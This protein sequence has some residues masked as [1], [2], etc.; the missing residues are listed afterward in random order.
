[1]FPLLFANMMFFMSYVANHT[2]FPKPLSSV[3]ERE[4]INLMQQGDEEARLKLIEHNMRLVAHIARK[5]TIAGQDPDDLISIGSI[6]LIK[7]VGT[8]KCDSGTQLATY[9]AK[10]IENEILMVLRAAQ[11]RRGDVSLSEAIGADT[12]GNEILLIDVLGT[13]ADSVVDEVDRRMSLQRVHSLI[14]SKLPKR[15]RYVLEL[16]YGLLDGKTRPQYEIAEMMGISRS[17]VSR[18][19]KKAVQMLEHDMM[20]GDAKRTTTKT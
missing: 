16:R 6:G 8:F 9:A 3:E 17:Y 11:K 12:E 13:D 1:M 15:E 4:C 14:K 19:E 5:Y 20:N 10:C 7:A 2:S 18:I